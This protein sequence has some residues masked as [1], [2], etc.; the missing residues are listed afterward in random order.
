MVSG[1]KRRHVSPADESADAEEPEYEGD[2]E[3]GIVFSMP[4]KIQHSVGKVKITD[5][6]TG[7]QENIKTAFVGMEEY[8]LAVNAFP[9]AAEE[10]IQAQHCWNEA[11]LKNRIHIHSSPQIINMVCDCLLAKHEHI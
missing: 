5:W 10:R 7:V 3:G 6:E 9:T 11:A 8:Y 2:N 4:V 1:T